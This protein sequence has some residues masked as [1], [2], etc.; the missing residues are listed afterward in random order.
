MYYCPHVLE[1]RKEVVGKDAY[2]RTVSVA[3][4]WETVGPCRC[5]DNTTSFVDNETGKAYV[6]SYHIVSDRHDIKAGDYVRAMD[7][8]V[9]RGEGEVRK[10]VRT[11]YLDYISIYV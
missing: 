11:N 8:D 10:V 5:D 3:T 4:V 2:N 9:V 7:G 1:V 6:P